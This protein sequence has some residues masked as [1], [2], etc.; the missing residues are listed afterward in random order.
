MLANQTPLRLLVPVSDYGSYERVERGGE[1]ER[2]IDLIGQ[3]EYLVSISSYF[4]P[5]AGA[6]TT[7]R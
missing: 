3:Q 1:E 4:P 2:G 6:Q 5:W 7:L